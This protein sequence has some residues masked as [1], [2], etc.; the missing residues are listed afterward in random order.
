LRAL[1]SLS[2]KEHQALI[3]V[4]LINYV[5]DN[6][7]TARVHNVLVDKLPNSGAELGAPTF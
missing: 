7:L 4:P 1:T 2:W 3:L 6:V 5:R